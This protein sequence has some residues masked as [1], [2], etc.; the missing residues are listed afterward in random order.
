VLALVLRATAASSGVVT[1]VTGR[2]DSQLPPLAVARLA[3]L[4][5]NK[6]IISYPGR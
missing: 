6:P 3:R 4:G 2:F 5:K 1:F